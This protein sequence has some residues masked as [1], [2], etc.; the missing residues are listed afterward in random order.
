MTQ[1]QAER[2]IVKYLKNEADLEELEALAQLLNDPEYEQLFRDLVKTNYAIDY[3]MNT[4]DT[5]Q[6]KKDVLRKIR[7]DKNP[8]YRFGK[9]PYLKYAAILILFLGLAYVYQQNIFSEQAERIIPK[10]EAITLEREDGMIEVI[11]TLATKTLKDT[12]GNL[13]GQQNKAQL[14][15]SKEAKI[16]N[17]VYNSLKV[18]YGKRFELLLSDGTK[19]RLNAGTSITYP[20]KFIKGYDRQV[21]LT[22]EAYFEVAKDSLHPF[23]ANTEELII[24]VVGTKFNVSAYPEDDISNVVLV[25]GLVDLHIQE[26]TE[27]KTVSLSPGL[28]ATLHRPSKS[29][30]T[31]NVNTSLYTAW[32]QDGLVFRNMPFKNILKKLERHYNIRMVNTNEA[33]GNEVFNASFNKES[34]EKVLSYFSDSY[35]IEYRIK[36]NTIYIE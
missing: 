5:T 28:K 20:V 9:Q 22:G 3:T 23:M 10:E 16:E 31:E 25:E 13:I 8:F 1:A 2:L 11:N 34:I 19:I 35:D 32:L 29:I 4:Y 7:H 15:Y 30:S 26:G 21:Y 27:N 24:N 14:A 17:L 6:L 12:R 36:D 33:L 18:P